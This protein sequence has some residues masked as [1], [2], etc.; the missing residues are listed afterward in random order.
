LNLKVPTHF[1]AK[2]LPIK[3]V[4]YLVFIYLHRKCKRCIRLAK[5]FEFHFN[6]NVIIDNL[7]R[8][9]VQ[10]SQFII[11][12]NIRQKLL[13]ELI[14]TQYNF[15][16]QLKFQIMPFPLEYWNFITQI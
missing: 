14:L 9:D 8:T 2:A 3:I 10:L 13:L 6:K 11:H 12:N 1:I 15:A 7:W 4:L 5:S 16:F